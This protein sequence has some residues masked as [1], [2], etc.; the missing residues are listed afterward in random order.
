MDEWPS[1]GS[2]LAESELVTESGSRGARVIRALVLAATGVVLAIAVVVAT[3]V[4]LLALF[5]YRSEKV[6]R[7]SERAELAWAR[8]QTGMTD[9][10]VVG[11]A[12]NPSARHGSCWTWGEGWIFDAQTVFEVCFED[13]RVVGK[14]RS[15]SEPVD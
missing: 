4:G 15:S 14:S 3:L 2:S 9:D 10:A 7:E 5:D 6:T 11:L 13:G 1:P 8:I 12:G